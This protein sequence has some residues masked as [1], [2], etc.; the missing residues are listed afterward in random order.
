MELSGPMKE[1]KIQAFV[2]G[3][4]RYE[5]NKSTLDQRTSS[6]R[7]KLPDNTYKHLLKVSLKLF[8]IL[9]LGLTNLSRSEKTCIMQLPS[10]RTKLTT[11]SIQGQDYRRLLEGRR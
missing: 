7:S 5:A 9:D 10:T 6:L 11:K 2:P 4:G 1:T 8:R 3:P